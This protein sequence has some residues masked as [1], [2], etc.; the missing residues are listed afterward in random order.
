MRPWVFKL[1]VFLMTLLWV[2]PAAA[3]AGRAP[4]HVQI[5]LDSSGSMVDNDPQRLSSLAGM[6][7]SDLA[8]PGDSVGVLSMR[9]NRFVTE[10]LAP[11]GERR[12]KV[13]ETMGST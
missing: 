1:G 10:P 5:V 9:K 11:I 7:F 12:K 8:A 2:L 4:I 6:I 13:A 3:D